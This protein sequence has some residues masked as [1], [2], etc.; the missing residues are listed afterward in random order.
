VDHELSVWNRVLNSMKCAISIV[1]TSDTMAVYFAVGA[2][3]TAA[4][5][6]RREISH[7]VAQ[8]K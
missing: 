7:A 2:N 3:V 6:S 4:S 5:S 1:T 8:A